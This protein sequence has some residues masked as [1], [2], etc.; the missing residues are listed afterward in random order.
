MG[1]HLQI[2]FESRD[3]A[4]SRGP[5]NY[6]MRRVNLLTTPKRDVLRL[7]IVGIGFGSGAGCQDRGGNLPL[8]C[9]GWSWAGGCRSHRKLEHGDRFPFVLNAAYRITRTDPSER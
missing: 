7:A 4:A 9:F 5:T 1:A 2:S 6:S 3:I 8:V